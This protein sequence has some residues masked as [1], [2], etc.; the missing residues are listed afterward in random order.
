M[1]LTPADTPPREPAAADGGAPAGGGDDGAGGAEGALSKNQLKKQAKEAEKARKKAERKGLDH[2]GAADDLAELALKP[3]ISLEPPTGT[4]DFYPAE[5]RVRSWLFAQF[6]E[7][8]RLFAFQEY[9]AP[10]LEYDELYRRKAGEEITGQMYNF[11]DKE[12]ADATHLRSPALSAGRMRRRLA[13]VGGGRGCGRWWRCTRLTWPFAAPPASLR[14]LPCAGRARGDA[15]PRDDTLPRAHGPRAR[16][17]GA[18]PAQVVL[19]AAVLALRECAARAQ[20]R[21]LPVVSSGSRA[22]DSQRAHSWPSSRPAR[23]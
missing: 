2:A 4:R 11:V 14:P 15:A 16:R 22:A 12:S 19:A 9:D 8:A 1:E 3:T 10:V 6:R 17:Q 21:A 5:M 20:A 13:R 23:T 7:V 18:A